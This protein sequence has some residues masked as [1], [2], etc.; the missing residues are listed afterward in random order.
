MPEETRYEPYVPP[1][2]K[3]HVVMYFVVFLVVTVLMVIN[4][5]TTEVDSFLIP[6]LVFWLIYTYAIEIVVPRAINRSPKGVGGN[7]IGTSVSSGKPQKVIAAQGVFPEMGVWVSNAMDAPKWSLKNYFTGNGYIIAP[8]RFSYQYGPNWVWNVDFDIY[9]DHGRLPPHIKAALEVMDEPKYKAE[10]PV[11]FNWFPANVRMLSDAD[12]FELRKDLE[13][14]G[15]SDLN[16]GLNVAEKW[17]ANIS[18]F[19]YDAEWSRAEKLLKTAVEQISKENDKLR[20][21][22]RDQQDLTAKW[23]RAS[24]EPERQ[25]DRSILQRIVGKE[26]EQEAEAR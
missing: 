23:K 22:I 15:V 17:A 8:M 16:A 7:I 4:P 26:D 3:M 18:P 10:W 14:I 5:A 20:Q 25:T 19:E 1:I 12:R 2:A 9:V 13:R 6:F 11:S 21:E 24:L